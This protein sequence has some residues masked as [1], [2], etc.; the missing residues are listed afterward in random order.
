MKT[1]AAHLLDRLRIPYEVR[2]YAYSEDDLDAV[3][4]A[5]KVGLPP[6]RVFKTLVVRGDKTGVVMACIPASADL[7]LKALAARSGNKRTEMV[8]VRELPG[9]T[10]YQRGGVSPLGGKGHAAV[11][12]DESARGLDR[13]SVSAGRRGVQLLLSGAG[14]IRA[15]GGRV[16][17]LT[18]ARAAGAD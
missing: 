17:R 13:V 4:A 11:F 10:G 16:A 14:L 2:E 8:P 15:T 7:D 6:E 5:A 18:R 12:I 3:T 1:V 9:L